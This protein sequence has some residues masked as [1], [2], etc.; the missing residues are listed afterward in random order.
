MDLVKQGC[1]YVGPVPEHGP[2]PGYRGPIQITGN[3]VHINT[4]CE[5]LL[6]SDENCAISDWMLCEV[7]ALLPWHRVHIIEWLD[8][9]E[10]ETPK[11]LTQ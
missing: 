4:E 3:G 10:V 7:P 6:I 8:I 11:C 1:V 5:Y 9:N 2:H